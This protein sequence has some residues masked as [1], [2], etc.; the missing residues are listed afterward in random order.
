LKRRIE[1]RK[2]FDS[3]DNDGSGTVTIDELDEALSRDPQLS[4]FFSSK[5]PSTSNLFSEI[6]ENGDGEVNWTEFLTFLERIESSTDAIVTEEDIDKFFS[7]EARMGFETESY[8]QD[9][10]IELT[11][12]NDE[13]YSTYMPPSDTRVSLEPENK[14]VVSVSTSPPDAAASHVRDRGLDQSW[15]E[16]VTREVR[17]AVLYA[18]EKSVDTMNEARE[19]IGAAIRE[20]GGYILGEE[21]TFLSRVEAAVKAKERKAVEEEEAKEALRSLPEELQ[22]TGYE[23]D[24][25]IVQ[26]LKN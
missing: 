10:A 6:D 1:I 25:E 14:I 11:I 22:G 9:I 4:N 3:I 15:L 5:I 13:L 26:F 12:F 2:I 23:G 18:C 7:K 24:A 8:A 16:A 19:E 17:K 20:K 21:G